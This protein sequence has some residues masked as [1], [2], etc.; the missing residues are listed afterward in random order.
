MGATPSPTAPSTEGAAQSH[1]DLGDQFEQS[2]ARMQHKLEESRSMAVAQSERKGHFP[3]QCNTL[4]PSGPLPT[5]GAYVSGSRLVDAIRL[6]E[7][8]EDA[9]RLLEVDDVDR[10]LE[11]AIRRGQRACDLLSHYLSGL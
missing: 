5:P 4:A 9:I 11:D 7:G 2:L 3:T 6:L 8:A 1:Q 10:D